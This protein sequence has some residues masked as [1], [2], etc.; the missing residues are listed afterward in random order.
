MLGTFH[1]IS[2]QGRSYIFARELPAEY[3]FWKLESGC[4]SGAKSIRDPGGF[5]TPIIH[6]SLSQEVLG[7]HC[8]AKYQSSGYSSAHGKRGLG[9]AGARINWVSGQQKKSKHKK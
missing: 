9:M 8:N 3:S 6:S 5:E 1:R 7:S 4:R 2:F